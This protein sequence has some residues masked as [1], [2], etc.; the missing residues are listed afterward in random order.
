M[1]EKKYFTSSNDDSIFLNKEIEKYVRNQID[2]FKFEV[3]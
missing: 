1:N 3:F 2:G